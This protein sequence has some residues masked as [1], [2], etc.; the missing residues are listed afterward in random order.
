MKHKIP[1][2][3]ISGQGNARGPFP[4]ITEFPGGTGLAALGVHPPPFTSQGLRLRGDEGTGPEH[5]RRQPLA[6]LAERLRLAAGCPVGRRLGLMND[7]RLG[8]K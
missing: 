3:F 7:L 1:L 6:P 5:H 8:Q 2:G 4:E